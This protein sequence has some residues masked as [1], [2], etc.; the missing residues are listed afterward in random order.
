MNL[1]K[2]YWKTIMV[3]A[4][5]LFLS[6]YRFGPIYPLQKVPN[7]DK[8][9][10]LLMYAVFVFIIQWDYKHAKGKIYDLRTYI[11]VCFAFPILLGGLIEVLQSTDFIGRSGDMY[12]FI[13][14]TLG[15]FVGWIIF[16]TYMKM[17]N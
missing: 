13:A 14:N 8:F 10:H 16:K 3:T 9:I 17:K 6:L 12:D 11:L 4:I 7:S 5:I 1:I 2:Q 15:V